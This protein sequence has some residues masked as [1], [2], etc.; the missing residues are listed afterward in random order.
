MN[1]IRVCQLM[2]KIKCHRYAARHY[3][4][5]GK[6]ARRCISAVL[7]VLMLS[8]C[9][10]SAEGETM[11]DGEKIIITANGME[12]TATLYGNETADAF[13]KI[14]PITMNMSELNGNEK[15]FYLDTPLPQDARVPSG[16][17]RNGDI[18]LFGSAC[19]VIFYDSFSTHYRYTPIARI[20]NPGP[21]PSALGRG[22]AEV[23]IAA[24]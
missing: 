7:L 12:F 16:G 19:L 8:A 13:K 17:I 11:A 1:G 22:N 15:Y 9:A 21:L 3:Y 10:A 14:L 5:G 18:M 23:A 20:D 4:D 24:E 6:M 2:A